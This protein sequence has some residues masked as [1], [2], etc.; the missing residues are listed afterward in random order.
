MLS[1]VISF[2]FRSWCPIVPEFF[3]GTDGT[4]TADDDIDATDADDGDAGSNDNGDPNDTYA[5]HEPALM[6]IVVHI[7]LV[8]DLYAFMSMTCYGI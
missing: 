5:N 4:Y 8:V 7:C 2:I 6:S 3:L 1:T